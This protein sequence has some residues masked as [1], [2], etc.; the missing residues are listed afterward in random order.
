MVVIFAVIAVISLNSGTTETAVNEKE[1]D[2]ETKAESDS[3]SLTI[4][5]LGGITLSSYNASTGMAGDVLFSKNGLDAAR[6]QES[7]FYMFGQRLPKNNA[8]E[9]QRINPNFEFR[10]ITK[11]I[12]LIAAIDGIVIDIK[13]QSGSSD[14]ELFIVPSENSNWVVGYDHITDV[15]VEKGQTV[16]AGQKL[17]V[18][19]K[20]SS[21][22]YR[23]ELQINNNATDTMHCPT[24]LLDPSVK[25][26]LGTQITKLA[27]DWTAWYGKDVF[28]A[29]TDGC[30]KPSITAAESEGR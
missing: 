1:T 23:Y 25:T 17:G 29:H 20:E 10:G 3:E 6:G 8:D 18:V 9:P 19:A 30:L 22:D 27:S 7:I 2:T 11:P 13:E 12:D 4:F 14:V 26:L 21:G 28:G 5:N 24:T 15:V 16:K